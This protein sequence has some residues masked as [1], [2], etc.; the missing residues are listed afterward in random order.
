MS[1]FTA[2]E[3][4]GCEL[5]RSSSGGARQTFVTSSSTH[6]HRRAHTHTSLSTI[7]PGPVGSL[8][9]A[10]WLCSRARSPLV[11]V[12]RRIGSTLE[13]RQRASTTAHPHPSLIAPCPVTPRTLPLRRTTRRRSRSGTPRSSSGWSSD[14]ASRR[15]R[16]TTSRRRSSHSSSTS[17]NRGRRSHINHD[18]PRHSHRRMHLNRC[19]RRCST[20]HRHHEPTP[21]CRCSTVGER[22][23]ADHLVRLQPLLMPPSRPCDSRRRHDRCNRR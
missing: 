17:I 4:V 9:A 21:T 20:I 3:F 13:T 7:A 6:T 10:P 5:A 15:P 16:S 19:R 23:S 14:A 22:C 18:W 1:H 12:R 11:T 2:D 8:P